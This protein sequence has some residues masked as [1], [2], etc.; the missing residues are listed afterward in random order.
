MLKPQYAILRFSKY[1]G[2]E[3]S[4]IEA[5]NERKK[6]NYSSNP[7]I[8]LSRSHLNYHLIPP[9]RHYRAEA[10]RQIAA[11]KCRTRSDS[12]RVVETL[13]TA[14]PNFFEG[15]PETEVWKF[16]QQALSFMNTQLDSKHII[17][18][19]VHLDEQTPHMHLSFVPLTKDQRL[20]AKEILG[21]RKKLTHWQDLFWEHMVRYFPDLE[22]GESASKTGRTY[23]PPRLFKEITHLTKQKEELEELLSG[24]NMFNAKEKVRD[25]SAVLNVYIPAAEKMATQIKRYQRIFD[26]LSA[27]NEQLQSELQTVSSEDLLKMIKFAQLERDYEAALAVLDQIP[28]EIL[29]EYSA[30]WSSKKQ[31]KMRIY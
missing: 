18:A 24:V 13:I 2:P 11:A 15:K 1:K 10:E 12:V 4:R 23:I 31:A 8:G 27:K 7:D 9:A 22:R 26:E 6:E 14:S 16:F 3:I 21:N 30:G 20:S 19:V 29:S 5:H 17:S 25:I 28:S